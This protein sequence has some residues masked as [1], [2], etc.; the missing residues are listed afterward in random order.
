[1]TPDDAH[2]TAV[3]G[4]HEGLDTLVVIILSYSVGGSLTRLL[5]LSFLFFLAAVVPPISLAQLLSLKVAMVSITRLK[6]INPL[7]K[8]AEMKL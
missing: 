8:L 1:M 2:V 4:M 6:L 7:L 3:A 5:P